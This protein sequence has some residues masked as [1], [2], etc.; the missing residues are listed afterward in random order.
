MATNV[1]EPWITISIDGGNRRWLGCSSAKAGLISRHTAARKQ[2]ALNKASRTPV[3]T[4]SHAGTTVAYSVR[5]PTAAA[6]AVS[7]VR[8]HEP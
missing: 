3:A 1:S 2:N 6:S 5:A 4:A 8:T 7:P